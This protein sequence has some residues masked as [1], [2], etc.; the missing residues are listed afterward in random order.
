MTQNY[1]DIKYKLNQI[2]GKGVNISNHNGAVNIYSLKNSDYDPYDNYSDSFKSVMFYDV[3]TK[4][5]DSY[6]EYDEKK[7]YRIDYGYGGYRI[8]NSRS[9]TI[10][11]NKIASIENYFYGISEQKIIDEVEKEVKRIKQSEIERRQK[12]EKEDQKRKE[13]NY[14]DCLV[15]FGIRG[16]P[17]FIICWFIVC[18]LFGGSIGIPIIITSI[19]LIISFLVCSLDK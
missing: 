2:I 11:F 15:D 4:V 16:I 5:T 14:N 8:E 6:F 12:W 13:K 9:I 7:M 17:L 19:Y 18:Y 1:S 10:Y 3:I